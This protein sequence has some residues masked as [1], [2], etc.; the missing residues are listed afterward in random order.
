MISRDHIFLWTHCIQKL[1]FVVT[2]HGI[3]LSKFKFANVLLYL[4][5]TSPEIKDIS[6]CNKK[7]QLIPCYTY[8]VPGVHCDLRRRPH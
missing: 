5:K 8:K 3:Y 2:L 4:V 6:T 1:Q 7:T